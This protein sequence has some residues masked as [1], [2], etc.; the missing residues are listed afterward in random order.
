MAGAGE[1]PSTVFQETI[2]HAS[3]CNMRNAMSTDM[4]EKKKL[5]CDSIR[6]PRVRHEILVALV[7]PDDAAMVACGGSGRAPTID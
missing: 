3:I 7:A 4:K 6:D 1:K 2:N 5:P